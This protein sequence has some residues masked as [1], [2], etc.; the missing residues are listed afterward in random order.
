MK[1]FWLF[2]GLLCC[3][4]C[5]GVDSAHVELNRMIGIGI[6]RNQAMTEQLIQTLCQIKRRKLDEDWDQIYAEVETAYWQKEKIQDTN[7][8]SLEDRRTIAAN[9]AKVYMD[10]LEGITRTEQSLLDESQKNTKLILDM[11]NVMNESMKSMQEQKAI[12]ERTITPLWEGN[13][14]KYI[15]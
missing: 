13:I 4:G 15:K 11:N 10:L 1:W 9:A 2:L 3:S 8:I 14:S 5:A 7:T 12:I 6:A